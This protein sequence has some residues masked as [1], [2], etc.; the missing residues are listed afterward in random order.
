MTTKPSSLS[1]LPRC[2][3]RRV[4]GLWL[5]VL[6]CLAACNSHTVY[7][8]YVSLPGYVWERSNALQLTAN[9]EQ[10]LPRANVWLNV[11]C[12]TAYPYANLD[13][14]LTTTAPNQAPHSQA[15]SV[16][17][18]DANDKNLGSGMGDMWDVAYPLATNVSLPQGTYTYQLRHNMPNDQV[19]MLVDVGIQIDQA[20]GDK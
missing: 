10:A 8:E 11:R 6:C 12:G 18:R 19:L 2:C 15:I 17:L 9:V 7:K 16:P 3:S 4:A 14:Q 1:L 13:L 20:E 5:L